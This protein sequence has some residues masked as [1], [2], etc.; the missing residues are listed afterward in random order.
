MSID[1]LNCGNCFTAVASTLTSMAVTVR[2]PPAFSTCS[3]N[4]LRSSSIAVMSALSNC[5]TC[6]MV[7]P[8]VAEMLRRLAADVAH[9]LPLDLAPLLEVGQR[10]AAARGC[11]AAARAGRA[12]AAQDPPRVLLDVVLRDA[13]AGPVPCT[14]L[15]S[16]PISRARRRTDGDAG[17][18]RPRARPA[19]RA[20]AAAPARRLR[21]LGRLPARHRDDLAGPAARLRHRRAFGVGSAPARRLR[22]PPRR[23]GAA[24]CRGCGAAAFGAAPRLRRR[25]RRRCRRRVVHGQD[26]G[27]DLDL[28]AL[29]DLDLL[30]DAGDRRGHFDRR[31]VGLELEHRLIARDRVADLDQHAGDVAA[32]DVLAQFG[33]FEFRH[34]CPPRVRPRATGHEAQDAVA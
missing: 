13:A 26:D 20:A 12:D 17:R 22:R 3:W 5:V 29:L 18:G 34:S 32:G 30:D 15:M 4:F 31:L 10:R 1:A 7:V 23:L 8:R 24:A 11:A 14:S 2:L 6:G 19:P 33:N 16:T 9:R 27:A 28:V 25:R 21:R